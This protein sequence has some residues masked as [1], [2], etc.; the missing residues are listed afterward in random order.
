MRELIRKSGRPSGKPFDHDPARRVAVRTHVEPEGWTPQR[1][2]GHQQWPTVLFVVHT[3]PLDEAGQGLR[4]GLWD[5]VETQQWT[6][7]DRGLILGR[8]LPSSARE[9][10]T[11]RAIEAG[12]PESHIIEQ[13]HAGELLHRV[14]YQRSGS[15]VAWD[16]GV[17]VGR[18]AADWGRSTK[19]RTRNGLSLI[20]ST[21]EGKATDRQ[22]ELRNGETEN[23]F[24]ARIQILSLGADRALTGYSTPKNLDPRD[25]KGSRR[26]ISLRPMAESLSGADLDTP[27]AAA[28][29]WELDTCVPEEPHTELSWAFSDL[30]LLGD[31]TRVLFEEHRVLQSSPPSTASS[32]GTYA[33][34]LFESM[35]LTPPL[36]QH[37]DFPRP[38]LAAA[39]GGYFSGDVFTHARSRHLPICKLDLGSA[40]TVA[41]HLTD[42]WGL[43]SAKAISVPDRDPEQAAIY[44]ERLA[45]RVRR[46]WN[47]Q[48]RKPL[49][50]EDW[51]RLARTIVWVLPRDDWLPHR[52][53]ERGKKTQAAYMVVGPVAGSRALPYFLSDVLVS[54]LRTGR[55]PKIVRAIRLV[56]N[57]RQQ[58]QPVRLPTGTII[59][60]NIDDPVFQVAVE[61]LRVDAD[62]SLSPN[63]RSRIRG[64]L[65]GI[66]VAASSGLPAQV[67]DDEPSSK[68]KPTLAWDPLNPDNAEPTLVSTEIVERPGT[69]YFPPVAAG[70]TASARLLLHLCRGAFEA[71]GGTVAYWD[72]DSLF[73]VTTPFG[74]ETI[75]LSGG[76]AITADGRPGVETLSRRQVHD[77]QQKI[78]EALSPYPADVRPNTYDR[79]G[80]FPVRVDLPVL[81]KSESEN[82][83]PPE[84]WG[85]EVEGPFYDGNRS[86]RYRTYH[87]VGPG[88][89]IEIHDGTPVVVQPTET[90]RRELSRVI[91]TNPSLHGIT[92][93]RP[94][95]APENFVTV[96]MQQHIE[97]HLQIGQSDS[98]TEVWSNEIAVSLVVATR[99]EAIDLHPDNIP[100]SRIAVATSL[101]GHQ[102]IAAHPGEDWC[103]PATG[104]PATFNLKDDTK[105]LG[106]SYQ[107]A[108]TLDFQIRRNTT[109][110]PTNALTHD[111]QHIGPRTEGLLR[112]A[113]T[114]VTAV[115]IIGRESRRW[116]DGRGILNPPE[117]N[118]Y[119][120]RTDPE[121]AAALIRK[122]Y[123]GPGA[124]RLIAEKTGLSVRTVRAILAGKKPTPRSAERLWEFA[125]QQSLF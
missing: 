50:A 13:K 104:T 95:N 79:T 83:P 109:A 54:I 38:I 30:N 21:L 49:S 45:R 80:D 82:E 33:R 64:Q 70:V 35:G 32:P 122:H 48:T 56:P 112:P 100:Y 87:I 123:W 98:D 78:E 103:D 26:I 10:L 62:T 94:N 27:S 124:A 106:L 25:K 76:A 52:P 107:V 74:G 51:K 1:L 93:Q 65:K 41:Y 88:A 108:R 53:R 110:A 22:P 115:D 58:L 61:R 24:N 71:E 28:H 68:P 11:K 99:V 90:Q 31:L 4:F 18:L 81:L 89:H 67:L 86:K 5:L 118:T 55:V 3:V 119:L 105:G 102:L 34:G 46:W 23:V 39:M 97:E 36:V 75:P 44:L 7:V 12:V 63:Q 72:T 113:P 15:L 20:L 77:I 120:T 29:L 111:N 116:G 9:G 16:I 117:I 17:D 69:W 114:M 43:Y 60:P 96:L 91:V 121:A 8:C 101:F 42:S 125:C 6:T 92:Y 14:C 57:G 73:V 19:G 59:D 66:A 85:L 84:A 40:Y 47:G 2:K 37:P